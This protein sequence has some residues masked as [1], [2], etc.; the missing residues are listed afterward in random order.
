[1]RIRIIIFIL[2]FFY[3]TLLVRVYYL[4]VASNSYYKK[5]SLENTIKTE[6]IAPVRGEILDVHN[7]PI[8]INQLGFKIQLKPHLRRK[9]SINLFHEELDKL[10]RLFPYLDKN[11]MLKKYKR[12]DSFYNHNYIDIVDFIPYNEMMPKY[13]KLLLD[14]NIKIIPSP[15]RK[16][17]F[18]SIASHVI[19]YVA[20]ANENDIKNDPLVE[21]IGYAGKNGI[22]KYYNRFLEGEAGK[23][24]V[25]VNANNQVIKELSYTPAKENRKITL[26]IDIELQQYITKLF[27]NKAGAV[28]VMRRDGAILAAGSFPEYNLNTFVTGISTKEWLELSTSLDKPFT[29]KLI[30]GLYPPGSTIKTGLG[31]IYITTKLTPSFEVYCT[32]RMPLGRRVFRCWKRA[33]HHKT[34]ITKA[35]RESCDDFFYKGSLEVG[36]NIMSAGLKRMGLGKKTGVDLPNEF[37]GTVPSREWKMKKYHQPWY[38]GETVNTSIGQGYMLVTP[39]QIAT[40]TALMAT[41]KLPTPHFAKF[42]GEKLYTPAPKDVLTPK[43]KQYLPLIQRAMREVCSHKKGTA[44]HYLHSKVPLAG[45]TGTAQVIGIKQDIKKRKLEHELEYYSRSHAWL[46]TYG[47]YNDPQY[48]VTVLVEHG[49]HGGAAAGGIV[50]DIYNWLLDHHYI[51]MEQH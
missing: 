2:G 30:N 43:E 8:A 4:S 26:H 10:Q 7:I 17:P 45:K 14:E 24:V 42:I 44:T 37:I 16:Y 35:I 47:P 18:D 46:T 12:Q 21:L 34:N 38:M 11:K 15:R 9:K 36:I 32:A 25:Q 51:K 41:G 19:G 40:F 3:I 1:M 31:L 23:R 20:K 5:L 22:E 6:Y 33:G 29:N 28:I 39:M 13:S 48:I 50:S 27:A 49:G